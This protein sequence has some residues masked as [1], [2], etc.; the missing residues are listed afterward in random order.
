MS[1]MIERV[2]RALF[3]DANGTSDG[4]ENTNQTRWHI[5]ARAAIEAMREPTPGMLQ[6]G[7]TEM[8]YHAEG[9]LRAAWPLMIDAALTG[10]K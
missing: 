5:A 10:G 7:Y 3:E 8:D 1:E 2:A 4:W 6:A 9:W